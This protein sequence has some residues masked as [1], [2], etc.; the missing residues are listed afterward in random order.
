[1]NPQH[2]RDAARDFRTACEILGGRL[3]ETTWPLRSAV[4]TASLAIELY[5]KYLAVATGDGVIHTHD[6][7]RLYAA[8]T[9]AIHEDI[10]HRFSGAAP[11]EDVLHSNRR[12]FW[13][14]RYVFEKQE[15]AF[16]LRVDDLRALADALEQ[17]VAPLLPSAL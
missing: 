10:R 11:I 12:V 16:N 14:W 7:E 9:P 3:G 13:E 17:V 15:A 5:L 2:I 6:A 8:L 1:M 4:V